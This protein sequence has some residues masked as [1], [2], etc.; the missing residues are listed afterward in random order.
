MSRETFLM[1]IKEH[2]KCNKNG[3]RL[4]SV[5]NVFNDMEEYEKS[6]CK[7]FFKWINKFEELG[8]TEKGIN[9]YVNSFLHSRK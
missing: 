5:S 3:T 9:F 6:V 4:I 8:Y 2:V 1:K 7:E